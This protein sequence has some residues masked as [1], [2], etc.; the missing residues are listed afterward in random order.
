MCGHEA[1]QPRAHNPSCPS[2]AS[3][4]STL[5]DAETRVWGDWNDDEEQEASRAYIN[6]P[7]GLES[8]LFRHRS[9]GKHC[10]HD[11]SGSG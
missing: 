9:S 7:G 5:A 3:S 8:I 1:T 10:P 2:K 4:R 6:G 11:E